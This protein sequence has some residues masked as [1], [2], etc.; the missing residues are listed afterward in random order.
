MRHVVC[1]RS[2]ILHPYYQTE[3]GAA[4]AFVLYRDVGRI[5]V[6]KVLDGYFSRQTPPLHSRSRSSVAKRH[7][8]RNRLRRFDAKL[9]ELLRYNPSANKTGDS[10]KAV[11]R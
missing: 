7:R 1:R 2:L 6:T 11:P 8:D 4:N 9:D 5:I 10:Q 3:Y